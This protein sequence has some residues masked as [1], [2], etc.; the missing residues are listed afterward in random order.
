MRS[1]ALT[2]SAAMLAGCASQAEP[3]LDYAGMTKCQLVGHILSSRN[4]TAGQIAST[5]EMGRNAGCFGQPHQS[6]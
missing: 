3:Q 2:L 4:A 5:M 1:I 6:R